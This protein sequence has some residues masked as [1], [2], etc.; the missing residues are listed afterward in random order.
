MRQKTFDRKT[1]YNLLWINFF[2]IPNFLKPW[3]D[4]QEI[5]LYCETVFFRQRFVIPVLCIKFFD[6]PEFLKH[7]RDAHKIFRHCETEKFWRKYV[8]LY[9]MHKIFRLPQTFWTIEGMP[10]KFSGTVRPKTFDRKLW[11]PLFYIKISDTTSF[12]NIARMLT[13]IFRL[14]E[15]N[16][17]R[18]KTL[19]PHFFIRKII[20][21]R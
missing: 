17:S 11:Y 14:C 19:I 5:F 21:K 16:V 12:W 2:D 18:Q 9:I 20:W 15:T 6:N 7:W 4:A 3:R 8:I 10:T 1:W 13:K